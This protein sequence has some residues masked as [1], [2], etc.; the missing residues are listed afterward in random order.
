MRRGS[1]LWRHELRVDGRA[2]AQFLEAVDDHRAFGRKT[3]LDDPVVAM[4]RAQGDVIHVHS[5]IRAY[6][7]HLLLTLELNYCRLG[8]E[9]RM[10][11]H[12]GIGPH[13]A[14]LSWTQEVM[15][16]GKGGRDADR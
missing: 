4:L 5:A 16:I 7:V 10:M 6:G 8:Y 15:R 3:A 9:H 13:A 12:F 14:K 11:P 1:R 2:F